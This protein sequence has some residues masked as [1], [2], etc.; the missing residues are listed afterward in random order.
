MDPNMG[1]GL[2]ALIYGLFAV[3]CVSVPLGIWKAVD[4]AIWCSHHVSFH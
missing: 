2:G 3:C 1:D 4:I